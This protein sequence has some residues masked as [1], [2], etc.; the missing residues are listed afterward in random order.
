MNIIN[1]SLKTKKPELLAPAGDITMLNA[2]LNNGADAVYFGV[3]NLNMR[4]KARNFKIDNL[5]ETVSHIHAHNAKAYLTVNTIVYEDEVL[6]IYPLLENA[7]NSNIDMIIAWDMGVIKAANEINI[8]LCISTQASVA[9][10]KAALFYKELGAKRIVPARECSLEQ[11]IEIKNNA[12]VEI[13]AFIHGAMCVAVSGRCF[14]SH[15]VF[16]KSANR[17]ECIQNCRREYKIIDTDGESEFILGEDYVL[18]PKDLCTVD[19][20][21]NL[22]DAGIDS[23]KIEGRKRSPEY[24]AKVSSIYRNAIDSYFENSLTQDKKYR[25]YD[26]LSSV[27]NRG[28]SSGFY[29]DVPGSKDFAEKYGSISEFKKVYAGKVLNYFQKSEIVHAV[30]E[31]AEIELNDD[32]YIIGESTGVVSTKIHSLFV[33]DVLQERA[34]KKSEITFP[35]PQ[36]VRK[37]DKL[38]KVVKK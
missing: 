20:I 5:S 27:Y 22:I 7:K 28:F 25:F 36:K 2:A 11:M 35:S 15:S 10:S 23:F 34:S 30:L 19:F 26:E 3:E 1:K 9:N 24:V 13:E 6:E 18:S 4:A 29:G 31:A 12:D 21:D 38:Y 33:N 8:P 14:M 17:G 16:D 37:G 32:I